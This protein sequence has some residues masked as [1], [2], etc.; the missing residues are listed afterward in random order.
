MI[1]SLSSTMASREYENGVSG[2][3][4]ELSNKNFSSED[5]GLNGTPSLLKNF[6][7]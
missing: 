3:Q 2:K 4:K 5:R 1:T 7:N 6:L